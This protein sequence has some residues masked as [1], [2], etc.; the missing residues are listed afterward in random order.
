MLDIASI[1]IYIALLSISVALTTYLYV[2]GLTRKRVITNLN[3]DVEQ[4]LAQIAKAKIEST[5]GFTKFLSE[6]RDEAF[7]YIE[8]VQS[9]IEDLQSAMNSNDDKKIKEAYEK[10]LS[11]LPDSS[12][13]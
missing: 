10:V 7:K 8:D 11:F 13:S 9:V 5:H 6:S 1:V 4:L 12:D 3:K 2:V